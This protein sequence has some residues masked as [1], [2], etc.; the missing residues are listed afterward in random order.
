MKLQTILFALAL[1]A[2]NAQ[3]ANTTST[4]DINALGDLANEAVANATGLNET[5]KEELTN[6]I[7]TATNFANC[8]SDEIYAGTCQEDANCTCPEEAMSEWHYL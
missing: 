8:L 5:E 1:A 3:D 4:E 6:V 2:A 7:N